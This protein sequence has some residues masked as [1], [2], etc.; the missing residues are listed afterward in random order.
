MVF[1]AGVFSG[2]GEPAIVE[3]AM[4]MCGLYPIG[5][6]CWFGG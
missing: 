1:A 3:P 4:D 2:I 6:G 5:W